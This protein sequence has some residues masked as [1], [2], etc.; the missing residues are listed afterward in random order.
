MSRYSLD[1]AKD[2]FDDQLTVHCVGDGLAH[3][4]VV[5]RWVEGVKEEIVRAEVTVV[6]QV[7]ITFRK[8]T[9]VL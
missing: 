1:L 4:E 9:F 8:F 2:I 7:V 6:A 5:E 3:V